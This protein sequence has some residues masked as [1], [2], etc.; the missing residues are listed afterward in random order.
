MVQKT[1]LET[2][3][4]ET[5]AKNLS[6]TELAE[7]LVMDTLPKIWNNLKG[8]QSKEKAQILFNQWNA[9]EEK[10][11]LIGY[12]APFDLFGGNIKEGELYF[13]EGEYHNG[14]TAYSTKNDDDEV[15]NTYFMPKEIVET[16]EA[17]YEPL[18]KEEPTEKD[19]KQK[20]VE[21]IEKDIA[22]REG[23]LNN[24]EYNR[25]YATAAEFQRIIAISKY[26]LK[27]IKELN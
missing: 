14:Y 7:Y 13:K 21:F 18:P 22:K 19:F 20:V 23:D 8:K 2:W 6:L 17:V 3:L 9:P 12:K 25:H 11:K 27:Q 1:E 24:A 5:K 4:K 10:G 15:S 26:L 16:W